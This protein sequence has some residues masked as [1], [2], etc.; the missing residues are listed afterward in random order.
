MATENATAKDGD[1]VLINL[2]PDVCLTPSK[3]GQPI[4]YPIMHAMD[5]SRQCSPNVFFRGHPAYLHDESYVDRVKGD[6]P[7]AGKGVVSG[8]HITIS[9][10]EQHSKSVFI[11]GRPLVRTGDQVWMNRASPGN[12]GAPHAGRGKKARWQC[13]KGQIAA[14]KSQLDDMPA[15]PQK[16]Q[17]Q[18]ATERFERNNVAVEKARLAQ[19]VYS[20]DTPSGATPEGWTDISNDPDKLQ[21]YGLEQA[22]LA[23]EG[24]NFRAKLYEPDPAVFGNDMPSMA[25][26]KGTQKGEDWKNN[27]AQ[28]V[29]MHSNYYESAV[30]IGKKI[31]RSGA[32]VEIAGHSLGGGLASA[33][34][35][36]SGMPA[37]TFNAAGLHRSTV[38]RYGAS[39][40]P[41]EIQAYRV[42]GEI[43]TGVQESGWR[44]TAAVASA[45]FAVG[46]IKGA[47]VGVLAQ[48]GLSGLMPNAAGTPYPVDGSGINPIDR[49]GMDQVIDGIEAQKTADQATIA[50]ATGK[51]CG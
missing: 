17:L 35:Q 26:F 10:S 24:S 4:P 30:G 44:G 6:E 23:Q 21:Q 31:K 22:D 25:V 1:F 15:G 32:S 48:W 50:T 51:T 49:H 42:D 46:G 29:N 14:A 9:R 11:N 37:T 20:P 38:E 27:F 18:Q 39:V 13:R 34:S 19:D 33:A 47:A 28:G 45:G 2:L 3:N 7:G 40:H 5:Q 41:T 43:L 8:T 36:A 16:D 12:A